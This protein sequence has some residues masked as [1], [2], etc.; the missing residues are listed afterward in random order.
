MGTQ[1]CACHTDP[2]RRH[3]PYRSWTRKVD[4]KTVTR[5]LDDAQLD[6]YEP[7]FENARRLRALVRELEDLSVQVAE[8]AEGWGTK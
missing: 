5:N 2:E 4:R 7:W 3:G 8:Q 1:R 6:R